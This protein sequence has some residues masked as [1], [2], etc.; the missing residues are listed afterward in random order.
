MTDNIGVRL[1]GDVSDLQRALGQGGA[2]VEQFSRKGQQDLEG[3]GKAADSAGKRAFSLRDVLGLFGAGAAIGTG[4]KILTG[5]LTQFEGAMVNAQVTAQKLQN[6]LSFAV[7]KDSAAR[8][9]VF[10]RDTT[11]ELGLEFNSSAQSYARLAAASRGTSM[12]GQKTRDLFEAISKAS[13]VMGMSVDETEGAFRAVQQ[14]MSKGK[15]QA[16]EL[17]GQLGERLPGAFHIA[18]RAMNVTTAELDKMLERGEVYA[19]EFL[20]RFAAALEQDLGDAHVAAANSAQAA[21]NRY[22]NAY[23]EFKQA[24]ADSGVYDATAARQ[25]KVAEGYELMAESLRDSKKAGEGA[26]V[27]LTQAATIWFDHSDTLFGKYIAGVDRAAGSVLGFFGVATGQA[28][29]QQAELVKAKEKLEL[30]QSQSEVMGNNIYW[31]DQKARVEAYITDL[32]RALRAKGKLLTGDDDAALAAGADIRAQYPTRSQNYAAEAKRVEANQARLS[33]IAQRLSGQSEGYQRTLAELYRLYVDGTIKTTEEYRKYVTDLI[34]KEGGIKKEHRVNPA[35]AVF[36]SISERTAELRAEQDLQQ[37]LTGAQKQAVK[38]LDDMRTGVLK[39][40]EA[41]KVRMGGALRQLL[42]ED[43]ANTEREAA[44]KLQAENA[45]IIQKNTEAVEKENEARL[46]A[47]EGEIQTNEK[48]R[49]EIALIGLDEISRTRRLQTIEEEHIKRLELD[50]VMAQNIEGNEAQVA[51]IEREINVRR[52][53]MRLLGDKGMAE[54]A[55]KSIEDAKKGATEV[56]D[57][58]TDALL[59][60]F[61]SGADMAENFRDT[62]KNMFRTLVLR[63]MIQGVMSPI[64]GAINTMMGGGNAAAQVGGALGMVGNVASMFGAGGM[65]GAF[66]AGAGW[67]T[68]AATLTGSLS[69]A[70]SLIMAPGGLLSGLSMMAGALGPIGLGIAA[71]A[72]FFGSKRG[73]PKTE[74]GYTSRKG[75]DSYLVED[76]YDRDTSSAKTIADTISATYAGLAKSLGIKDGKLDVAVFYALDP[77]GD[78]KTQLQVVGGGYNRADRVGGI[79]NVERGEDA[80]KN[81]VAAETSRLLLTALK[82]SDLGAKFKDYLSAVDIN[83]DGATIQ[84][85]IENVTIVKQLQDVVAGLGDRFSNL[86]SLGVDAS[87]ALAEIAGG[88]DALLGSLSNF[89]DR[90]YTEEEKRAQLDKNT[91]LAFADLGIVMPPVNE[92]LRE[93]YRT[94]VERLGAMDLSVEANARAYADI[95]KLSGAVDTLAGSAEQVASNIRALM[96]GISESVASTIF[97]MQYGMGTNEEKYAMLDARGDSIDKQMRSSDDINEIAALA[98]QEIE[99]LTQAW[100]LLSADQQKATFSQFEATLK[101]IDEFVS[102]KGADALSLQGARDD[103]TAETIATHVEEAIERGLADAAQRMTEAAEAI[104]AAANRPPE[105][106]EITVTRTPGTEVS[107]SGGSGYSTGNQY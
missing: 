49:E 93:W 35:D 26:F 106:V 105:P 97:G 83:A 43:Q 100:G 62:L 29:E 72:S 94:E 18:A 9:M 46:K 36:K 47:L 33:A 4:W 79:E 86:A 91:A 69:A 59:R 64:N 2:S 84:K 80:L 107:I 5:E 16:E 53:R 95:L 61:E 12:E 6:T 45:K 1:T 77:K 81:E 74:S 24:L 34:K 78:A 37:N 40:T 87:V 98:E 89:Y 99:L 41:E 42:V 73:G 17:R 23:N 56:G 52:E 101:E 60:G 39:L 55:Q 19:D 22:T 76:E 66:A 14:M 21:F 54:A 28:R 104:R 65:G 20:P 50:L 13:T 10:L 11:R 58:L 71:L 48:L 90:F 68:G 32:E 102:S 88:T 57:S 96:S 63:P 25:A 44:V 27:S 15:V 75:L 8:D 92:G 70:T 51:V 31:K 30:L 67:L 85:A 7:G 38:I 82:D 3:F 103:K